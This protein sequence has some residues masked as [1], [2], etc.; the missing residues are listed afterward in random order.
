ML[1][2]LSRLLRGGQGQVSHQGKLRAGSQIGKAERAREEKGGRGGRE[3]GRG[4]ETRNA[5]EGRNEGGRE[6]S[7]R[8][9]THSVYPSV[10]VFTDDDAGT[11]MPLL[12]DFSGTTTT[13]GAAADPCSRGGV[14]SRTRGGSP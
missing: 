14:N 7:K 9:M 4:R 2:G 10:L 13:G 11:A 6:E 12:G 1:L 5:E 3:T 8:A